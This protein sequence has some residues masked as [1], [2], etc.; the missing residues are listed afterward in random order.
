MKVINFINEIDIFNELLMDLQAKGGTRGINSMM[1]QM[2]ENN[3][4]KAM[5]EYLNLLRQENSKSPE[6]DGG[7]DSGDS[8]PVG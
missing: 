1:V 4:Q 2:L 3:L 5:G 6:H 8:L 7:E